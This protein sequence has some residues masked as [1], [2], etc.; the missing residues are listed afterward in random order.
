MASGR[1]RPL[2]ACIHPR[3][4]AAALL[5]GL[6][7]LT[8]STSAGSSP[9]DPE[10]RIKTA[11]PDSASAWLQRYATLAASAPRNCPP[12]SIPK[13]EQGIA[14]RAFILEPSLS[15]LEMAPLVAVMKDAIAER[16]IVLA[17]DAN[18]CIQVGQSGRS[19][20]FAW[21]SVFSPFP[22][23]LLPERLGATPAVGI[24]ADPK[25][26]RPWIEL[27]PRPQFVLQ[28]DHDWILLGLFTG[29]LL[30]FLLAATLIAL[31]QGG[32][33]IWA[34]FAYILC[35][36][37]YQFQALGI[38]R[39]WLPFWPPDRVFP[40]MQA[41]ATGTGI[42]SMTLVLL[43]FL[44]PRGRLRT[45]ML[46]SASLCLGAFYL[47]AIIP[48]LYQ[49]AAA[50]LL[51]MAIPV[52]SLLALRLRTG[53]TSIRWFALGIVASSLGAGTQALTIVT[54]G[55]WLPPEAGFAT[56]FGNIAEA[57]F[58]MLAII[59][60]IKAQ[61]LSLQE[62]RLN[63]FRY[64]S[65]TDSYNRR[66]L[67]ER[68]NRAIA[69]AQGPDG[70]PSGLLYIDLV[71]FQTIKDRFGQAIG[72]EALRRFSQML[73]DMGF[74]TDAIGR[75]EGHDFVILMRQD[76]HFSETEGA[77]ATI[78]SR[79]QEAIEVRG[80][81][82][83][84]RPN[85]GMLRIDA[86]YA[87]V[88]EVMEDANR[89]LRISTQ[90]G[91]RRTTLFEPA[92]RERAKIEQALVNALE[93]A[94]RQHQ[95][96]LYYQPTVVLERMS[97]IGF[98]ALLHCPHLSDQGISVEQTFATAESAGL[99][100]P[101]GERVIELALTQIASWQRQGLWSTD[102]FLSLNVGQQQL[103][104]RRFLGDLHRAMQRH[105]IDACSI[106]L[107]ITE[108]SL[109]IDLDWSRHVLPRLL[110]QHVLIGLDNFGAGLASLTM[111]TDLQ[112]DYIKLDRRLVAGLSSLPRAQNL[113]RVARLFATEIG[114]LSIAEG[115]ETN[116]QLETL[117]E[118]G[119]E[120]GQGHLIAAPM[121]G[122]E[123]T[124]WLQ[125]AARTHR[126]PEAERSRAWQ[127]H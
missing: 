34:Y 56:L 70:R 6:I 97:P 62:Q 116:A 49:V 85:I 19:V 66:Y 15:Q 112:P 82:I 120:H 55:A 42:L 74:K 53:E 78:L 83:L 20:P 44:Q 32:A 58:W 73:Q 29:I 76:A 96:D 43:L 14:A 33:L 75:Y 114:C 67:R 13:L 100:K 17:E 52:I 108:R 24:I 72:D 77:A 111:L 40:L 107:E 31:A 125:L 63:E 35:A 11:S 95:I 118:L 7:G 79:F 115:I 103:I 37:F 51:L 28:S 22:N 121:S 60:R 88:D 18:G 113:A 87:D 10:T 104:D 27:V 41:L 26:I 91:G 84:L 45:L 38:G 21:R 50:A 99:L 71:G 105:H 8:L 92:M 80:I 106:R 101:L 23:S 12:A 68:I 90:L 127:L 86:Q 81:S 4:L 94:I 126:Q 46:A 48:G 109:G 1:L 3:W 25:V 57:I 9:A 39:V 89:A 93:E 2:F 119:F 102:L 30:S 61:Y 16:F 69:A 124:S 36:L 59:T 64:D 47:S 123:T 65:L 122:A 54:Q 117:R 5:L 110:N 98:E